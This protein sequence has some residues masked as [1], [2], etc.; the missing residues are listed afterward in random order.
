[1]ACGRGAPVLSERHMPEEP[2][3]RGSISSMPS[4]SATSIPGILGT[5]YDDAARFVKGAC[6][7]RWVIRAEDMKRSSTTLRNPN[8]PPAP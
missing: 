5:R 4:N 8:V 3:A 6:G 1:M 7:G 2:V